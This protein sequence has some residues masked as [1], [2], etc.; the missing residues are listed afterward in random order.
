LKE[1]EKPYIPALDEVE[2]WL[3]HVA[4]CQFTEYEMRDGTAW[5]ILNDTP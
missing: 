1:I 5:K 4:Y 2:E 3:A